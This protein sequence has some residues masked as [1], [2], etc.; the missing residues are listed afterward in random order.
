MTPNRAKELLPIITAFSEGK[1]IE[2]K[3]GPGATHWKGPMVNAIFYDHHE[4]RIK[5]EL[6]LRPWTACDV[7]PGAAIRPKGCSGGWRLIVGAMDAGNYI[8]VWVG[9]TGRGGAN[10]YL[11]FEL[12]SDIH[13]HSTDG[14]KT[15]LPCGVIE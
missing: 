15:W 1:Q 7:P 6:K 10:D 9:G 14:G 13:E 4:Y 3:D 2:W 8:G 11:P 12:V 5:P